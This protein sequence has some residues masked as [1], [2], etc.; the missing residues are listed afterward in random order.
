MLEPLDE[1]APGVFATIKIVK[2]PDTGRIIRLAPGSS[3]TFG[4][5]GENDVVIED[6]DVSRHHCLFACIDGRVTLT[7]LQSSNGTFVFGKRIARAVLEGRTLIALGGFGTQLDFH[8]G[9]LKEAAPES[10]PADRKL[11]FTARLAQR[12][13]KSRTPCRIQVWCNTEDQAFL[14]VV[15]DIGIGGLALTADIELERGTLVEVRPLDNRYAAVRL[16]TCWR[17]GK[18][19]VPRYGTR[20]AQT[21]DSLRSSWVSYALRALGHNEG[22]SL[23]RRAQLRVARRIKVHL[24]GPNGNYTL[25]SVNFGAGGLCA[26][27]SRLPAPGD[28]LRLEMGPL[29]TAATV[30]WTQG[31]HCGI[32]FESL[33]Q[34]IIQEMVRQAL[35]EQRTTPFAL[36]APPQAGERLDH[37]ELGPLVSEDELGRV[38]RAFDTR[39]K[40]DVV[41]EVLLGSKITLEGLNR[42]LVELRAVAEVSHP[43]LATIHEV[44][45]GHHYYIVT[46]RIGG[47]PLAKLLARTALTP[48]RAVHFQRQILQALHAVHQ[49]GVLHR[50]L[51]TA[52][53]RVCAHDKIK[54]LDFGLAKLSERA[55]TTDQAAQV[56]GTPSSMAPEQFDTRYG[57]VDVQT[58]LYAVSVVFYEMLTGSPPFQAETLPK[59]THKILY[60]EPVHP[61]H[62]NPNLSEDLSQIVLKGLSKGKPE[63][64]CTCLAFL[65]ALDSVV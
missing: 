59:L 38:F 21:P 41:I 23:D 40:R 30:I 45:T 2:G 16:Q 31:H 12:R 24:E 48:H 13:S 32:A 28:R 60:S 46:E 50:N 58:D 47:E 8:Y 11:D 52:N 36:E 15:T 34:K 19:T 25:Q 9:D 43:G 4:R 49:V 37:Y 18:A 51:H 22:R 29:Q 55:T 5:A 44:V 3:L 7:D 61:C 42:F 14:G 63:R 17:D 62:L 54:V 53:I 1:P 20:Y 56:W 10:V 27:G 6:L 35:E 33:Q 26:E 57:A 39:L 65:E 64:W